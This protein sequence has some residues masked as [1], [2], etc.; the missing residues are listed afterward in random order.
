MRLLAIKY[1][2][3]KIVNA[4]RNLK[5]LCHTTVF[6]SFSPPVSLLWT[7]RSHSARHNRAAGRPGTR[8][9]AAGSRARTAGPGG[10]SKDQH[11]TCAVDQASVSCA[12]AAAAA[13]AS[14]Q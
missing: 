6:V 12:G 14:R 4:L 2:N 5:A 3:H 10:D 9:G 7:M 13:G 8:G 11:R 1:G